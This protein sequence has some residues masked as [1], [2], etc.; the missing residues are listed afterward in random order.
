M[1]DALVAFCSPVTHFKCPETLDAKDGRRSG[2]ERQQQCHAVRYL[3]QGAAEA[4]RVR[5]MPNRH[6][7]FQG[8]PGAHCTQKTGGLAIKVCD[9]DRIDYLV[10]FYSKS[11]RLSISIFTVIVIDLVT[12]PYPI[13]TP[14][15]ANSFVI[16]PAVINTHT[17]LLPS[18][19]CCR[20]RA[21]RDT[22]GLQVV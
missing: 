2:R 7:L 19:S 11:N 5:S 10:N 4:A 16:G 13:S 22:K 14:P 17:R 8:L 20:S 6:L 12:H 9:E 18:V 3:L 21:P 1:L 15:H